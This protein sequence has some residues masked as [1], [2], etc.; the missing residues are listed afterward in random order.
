MNKGLFIHR[1]QLPEVNRDRRAEAQ[2]IPLTGSINLFTPLED[3]AQIAA[4]QRTAVDERQD[5]IAELDELAQRAST[6]EGILGDPTI[7]Q[8]EGPTVNTKQIDERDPEQEAELNAAGQLVIPLM[9]KDPRFAS[10]AVEDFLSRTWWPPEDLYDYEFDSEKGQ[11]VF[12]LAPGERDAVAVLRDASW[13]DRSEML[14]KFGSRDYSEVIEASAAESEVG[15]S[16]AD[17]E[18][19]LEEEEQLRQAYLQTP[20]G[21][22]EWAIEA[23]YEARNEARLMVSEGWAEEDDAEREEQRAVVSIVKRIGERLPGSVSE[24][25]IPLADAEQ[26]YQEAL[27]KIPEPSAERQHLQQHQQE[28]T[29]EK[30][31]KPDEQM[32]RV[33]PTLSAALANGG[34]AM[35]KRHATLHE[36]AAAATGQGKSE[37]EGQGGRQGGQERPSHSSYY[38]PVPVGG[39][40]MPQRSSTIGDAVVQREAAQKRRRTQSI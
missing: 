33:P 39:M 28:N 30:N 38:N 21:L 37:G 5:L 1:V 14:A 23:R 36:A 35:P 17:H 18:A 29:V 24:G 19:L 12:K 27:S 7:S 6:F 3:A 40:S 13:Q 11:T 15:D 8:Q 22:R 9:E 26:R 20:E 31:M 25:S 2:A 4:S 10:V 16:L 34:M 32:Q